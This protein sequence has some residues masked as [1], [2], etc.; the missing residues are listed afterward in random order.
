MYNDSRARSGR[1]TSGGRS[2][3]RR[4]QNQFQ[5]RPPQGGRPSY[6]GRSGGRNGGGGGRSRHQGQYINPT[7]YVNKAVA[8][9]DVVEYQSTRQFKDFG[10]AIELEQTLH[11]R[12]YSTPTPIQ[13][14]AIPHV[15]AGKD[16][17]GLAN[18]GTGKTAAFVLP[19]IQQLKTNPQPGAALIIAPTRELAQQIEEE[20]RIFTRGMNLFSVLCVGGMGIQAQIKG[21]N[22]RPQVVI[23]TPGRLKDLLERRVLHL[24]GV[25][26]FVLDEVDRM[27]DMGF[28]PDIQMLISQLPVKRQ[29]LGFSATITPKIKTLLEGML[30]SPV[31]VSVTSGDTSK[32]VEQDVIRATSPDQKLDALRDL[33]MKPELDKVLIF[34]QTKH[35]VQKLA[36]TLS[37]LGVPSEAIHGNKSQPQRARALKSFKDG[38]VRALVA[39][40]VA[41]RGLD[42]PN[43]S[44]V[45]NF[46]QPMSYEDYVHRIGRTGRAGKRGHALTF[47]P[48]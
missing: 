14:Q 26:F 34:G 37:K 17:I 47:I 38:R 8:I 19:L 27:L 6:G 9:A 22:R 18:T 2:N 42:I 44:H 45:I 16:L 32:N 24:G 30:Q 29:S 36:D 5:S 4:S 10:F 21:L 20:F 39:T 41:A 31:T 1:P 13:D 35:G 48:A 46:D 33:L 11:N 3:D 43:V 7:R 12:G 15:M 23:G 25:N 28:L 40:D